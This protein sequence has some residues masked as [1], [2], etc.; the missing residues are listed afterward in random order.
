MC[1]D[2]GTVG[3]TALLFQNS[4]P[5][6]YQLLNIIA[7]YVL[8]AKIKPKTMEVSSDTPKVTQCASTEDMTINRSL[9]FK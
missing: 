6:P 3:E 5:L 8:L 1:R 4:F 7:N 2:H 9:G